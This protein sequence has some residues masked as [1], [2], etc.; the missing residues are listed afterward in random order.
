MALPR[1]VGYVLIALG[2]VLCLLT[3]ALSGGTERACPDIDSVMYDTIGIY[4]A[5][6]ELI[7]VD[8][9]NLELEWYDGC[10]WR[11]GHLLYLVLG[12]TSIIVGLIVTMRPAREPPN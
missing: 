1:W 2:I 8:W 10:N 12:I 7:G 6:F 11:S 4:P 3:F 9:S 5:E